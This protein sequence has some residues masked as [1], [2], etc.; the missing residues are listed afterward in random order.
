MKASTT[1]HRATLRLE[2]LA[3]D[4]RRTITLAVARALASSRAG[5]DRKRWPH[6]VV[7]LRNDAP[8]AVKLRADLASALRAADLGALAR[9][10]QARRVGPGEILVFAEIDTPAT[11]GHP[12]IAFVGCFVI[13]IAAAAREYV[14]EDGVGGGSW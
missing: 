9:E 11:E 2:E 6:L 7:M 14:R 5:R 10:V 1:T 13:N 3:P 8:Q 12:A 4:V